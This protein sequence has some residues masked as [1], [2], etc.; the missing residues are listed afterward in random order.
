M[1]IYDR[2]TAKRKDSK[3]LRDCMEQTVDEL[4]SKKTDVE[5]PGMLLGDIQ[6]GKTR[7]FTGIIALA[8][9]KKYDVAVVLTKGTK[10]LVKQTVQRFKSEFEEFEQEDILRIFDVMEIPDDLNEYVIATQNLILVVKKEDDN[11][12]RLTSL[13]F[14][15]YPALS[16]KS[17][18]IV[19]DEADFVSIGYRR[20][21]NEESGEKEI[22]LNVISKQKSSRWI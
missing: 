5:H 3:E 4:L 1:G 21:K 10:A 17:V 11:I 15:T 9:D 12:R 14:V 6:S 7:G 16:K 13:F 18:L 20:I 2:L 19:D 22:D 8:F